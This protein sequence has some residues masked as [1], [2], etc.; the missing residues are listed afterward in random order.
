MV[1]LNASLDSRVYQPIRKC[2]AQQ[3]CPNN[4][5]TAA[6]LQYRLTFCSL[7]S[8]NPLVFV[9][10]LALL[11]SSQSVNNPT[12]VFILDQ[13]GLCHDSRGAPSQSMSEPQVSIPHLPPVPSSQP[14]ALRW[15]DLWWRF[16]RTFTGKVHHHVGWSQARK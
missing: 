10:S 7:Y 5:P 2:S 3:E 15:G 6:F 9:T 11:Q 4:V 14:S 13:L 12:V 1:A 16:L 8:H